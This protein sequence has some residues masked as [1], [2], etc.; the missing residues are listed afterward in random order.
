MF[1]KVW[2]IVIAFLSLTG[3]K[4]Q[5]PK[6]AQAV[7]QQGVAFM[8]KEQYPNAMASFFKAVA[9]YKNFD[10]AYLQ[11]GNI[12]AKFNSYD[13]AIKFYKLALNCNPKNLTALIN[14]ASDVTGILPVA[15]GG[16]NISNPAAAGVVRRS[17]RGAEGGGRG[18]GPVEG[19]ERRAAA[20][21]GV[22]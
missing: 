1:K 19:R 5:P 8:I 9:L 2:I 3:A 20:P 7:Y 21:A 10:S 13:T 6:N 4:A 11:M 18:A 15:N 17:C 22:A 14:L 16:T 12:N